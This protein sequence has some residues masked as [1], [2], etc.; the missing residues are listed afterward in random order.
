M[1]GKQ[2]SRITEER[3]P[4]LSLRSRVT[5]ILYLLFLSLTVFSTD[6]LAQDDMGLE[7][8]PPPVRAISK[9]ERTMLNRESDVKAHTVLALNLMTARISAAEKAAASENFDKMFSEFGGFQGILDNTLDFLTRNNTESDKVLGNFK[10]FEI[11]LRAYVPRIEIVRRELPLRYEPYVKGLIKYIRE[12]RTRALDPLF[13]D[14]VV[15]EPRR[16]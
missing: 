11:G 15:R 1:S 13:G 4:K 9:D 3:E 5:P 14:S 10:R 8:A 2:R 6:A 12:S 16:N 7:T